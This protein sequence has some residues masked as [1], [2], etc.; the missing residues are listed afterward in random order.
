MS[1]I[2]IGTKKSNM[3]ITQTMFAEAYIEKHLHKI[4]FD[5]E[6]FD[7]DGFTL[8]TFTVND[9]KL[10]EERVSRNSEGKVL[11]W[12]ENYYN[13]YLIAQGNF[14][15]TC[16][17]FNNIYCKPRDGWKENEVDVSRIRIFD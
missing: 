13:Q 4:N 6:L 7:E 9:F 14:E 8:K 11:F 16:S 2:K 5:V 12:Y 3:D 17:T 10:I 15:M 1:Y